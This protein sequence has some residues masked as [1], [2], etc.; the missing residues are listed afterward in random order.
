MTRFNIKSSMTAYHIMHMIR[1]MITEQKLKGEKLQYALYMSENRLKLTITEPLPT[2]TI[3][4]W[5]EYLEKDVYD[6]S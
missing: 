6:Q 3:E 5:N 4:C 1:D 2:A